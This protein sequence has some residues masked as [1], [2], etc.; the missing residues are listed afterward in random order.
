MEDIII[1]VKK[2]NKVK[3][4]KNLLGEFDYV[5]LVHPVKTSVR[6]SKFKQKLKDG[7]HAI[8]L[9]EE[10]KIRLKSGKDILNGL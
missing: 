8:K 5:E 4:I 1:K 2:K 3:F 6:N 9:H 7:F 10:G